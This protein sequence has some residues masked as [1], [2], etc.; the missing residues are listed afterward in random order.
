MRFDHDQKS[1]ITKYNSQGYWYSAHMSFQ[2]KAPI[3]GAISG[4]PIAVGVVGISAAMSVSSII[5][6]LI[7]GSANL[8]MSPF[9]KNFKAR[10]GLGQMGHVAT[11]TLRL[12]LYLPLNSAITCFELPLTIFVDDSCSHGRA[13]ISFTKREILKNEINH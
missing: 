2:Q 13:K 12:F 8:I 6:S 7:K 10:T 9:S 5:E 11:R 4:L 1:N 3:L